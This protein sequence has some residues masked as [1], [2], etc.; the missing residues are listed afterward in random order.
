MLVAF[1]DLAP[2]ANFVAV[3]ASIATR[4]A[5]GDPLGEAASV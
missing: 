2:G 1:G 5:D 3:L 4:R